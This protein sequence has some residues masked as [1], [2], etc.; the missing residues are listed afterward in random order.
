MKRLKK[1]EYIDY[2]WKVGNQYAKD[3]KSG[4][5]VANRW[6]KAAIDRYEKDLKNK[7]YHF[8]KEEVRK[9]FGFFSV[10][11]VDQKG[12]Q[13]KLMPYQCFILM[14]LFGFYYKNSERRKYNYALIFVSRKNGKTGFIAGLQLYFMISVPDPLCLSVGH[15]PDARSHTARAAATFVYQTPELIKRLQP[16]GPQS[17]KNKVVFKKE[18]KPGVLQSV[19]STAE[20]LDGFSTSSA[21]LDEI[22]AYNDDSLFNVIKSSTGTRFS[23]NENPMVTLISTAGFKPVGFCADMVTIGKRVLDGQA[24]DDSFFYMIYTL[25]DEDNG[26]WEDDSKWIKANP[27]L[28]EILDIEYLKS[29]FTQAKNLTTQLPNFLTKHLNIFVNETS[30]WISRGVYSK[31]CYNADPALYK[32]LTGFIGLDLSATRD[33]T[34]L[35]VVFYDQDKDFYYVIPYFWRAK[36]E[37]KRFRKGGQDLKEW[38][39]KGYITESSKKTIDYNQVFEKIKELNQQFYIGSIT[40]DRYLSQLVLPQV[41][42]LSRLDGSPI[43]IEP[44]AQTAYKY[45]FPMTTFEKSIYDGNCSLTDNPVFQWNIDNVVLYYDT[46]GNIKPMKNKGKDA[47]DGIVSAAMAFNGALSW[48]NLTEESST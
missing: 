10:L 30:E 7:K 14:N 28:G 12:N 46:N 39:D 20:R 45:S 22:H 5:I 31:V 1:A 16:Q 32:D 25:D 8:K 29:E 13:F 41:E 43:N 11:N 9:V 4:K 23:N 48:Y 35:V 19:V 26:K 17:S 3:I 24:E 2:C 18:G 27:A 44:F 21:V 36:N 40:F 34:S 47:I 42:G 15:S 33:L 37:D 38:I 6:I